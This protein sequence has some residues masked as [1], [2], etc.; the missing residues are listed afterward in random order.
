M[1]FPN[2]ILYS[3]TIPQHGEKVEEVLDGDNVNTQTKLQ[4]IANYERE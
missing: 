3:R 2:T 4:E 1:S